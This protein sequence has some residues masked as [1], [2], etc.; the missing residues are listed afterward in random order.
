MFSFANFLVNSIL[1]NLAKI[2][3]YEESAGFS[4]G[5]YIVCIELLQR[6]SRIVQIEHL[7]VVLVLPV[8]SL[9]NVSSQFIQANNLL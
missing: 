5:Q 1:I 9:N 3:C 7:F 4:S 6:Q 8:E 2:S